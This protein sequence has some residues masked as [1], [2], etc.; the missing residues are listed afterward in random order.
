MS[1]EEN[2]KSSN[3]LPTW[4]PEAAKK[5]AD[6]HKQFTNSEGTVVQRAVAI[7]QLEKYWL[8]AGGSKKIFSKY[9][10]ASAKVSIAVVNRLRKIGGLP[11]PV[12]VLFTGIPI[13]NRMD[14]LEAFERSSRTL[15]ASEKIAIAQ[16]ASN[17]AVRTPPPAAPKKVHVKKSAAAAEP[18][19]TDMEM[20]VCEGLPLCVRFE[21]GQPR[22]RDVDLAQSLELAKPRNIRAIIKANREFLPALR[23]RPRSGRTQMPT[24][25]ERE[26]E[27]EEF[28]LTAQDALFITSQCRTRMA[29]AITLRVIKGFLEARKY[30]ELLP[31]PKGY[32]TLLQELSAR[33]ARLEKNG[34][35]QNGLDAIAS[36]VMIH[37]RNEEERGYSMVGLTEI[38]ASKLDGKISPTDDAIREIAVHLKLIGDPLYTFRNPHATSTSGLYGGSWR[39]L[40][41]GVQAITPAL[42]FYIERREVYSHDAL[43]SPKERALSDV[44]VNYRPIG[45]GEEQALT[46]KPSH[47]PRVPPAWK[48]LRVPQENKEYQLVMTG[49]DTPSA[50]LLIKAIR[51]I[52][53]MGLKEAKDLVELVRDKKT[54]VVVRGG[55]SQSDA[56][57]Y[58]ARL[59]TVGGAFEIQK[60]S[61]AQPS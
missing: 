22:I 44:R 17:N 36:T 50:I 49:W 43:G 30:A 31:T 1:Q 2:K 21:D 55:L 47:A 42:L 29:K 56:A 9:I 39:F 4:V 59:A 41:A 13:E 57:A 38:L 15:S 34:V 24:G 51:G 11:A 60:V 25:G 61:E 18:P 37:Q 10:S 16:R 14:R 46:Y 7:S 52:N 26:D 23:V 32:D 48:V 40:D 28:W 53:N 35:A 12:L 8:E 19:P 33:L 27:V 58:G 45:N 20:L 3:G 54:S 5:W 6:T